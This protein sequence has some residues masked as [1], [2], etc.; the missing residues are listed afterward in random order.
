MGEEL[1]LEKTQV[2]LI[3]VLHMQLDIL[4]KIFAQ[5]VFV[6]KFLYRLVMQ[7]ELQSQW[8]YMLIPLDH[9]NVI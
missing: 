6:M 3:E 5:Q 1:F 4:Q 7:L 9:Q 8:V 2:K